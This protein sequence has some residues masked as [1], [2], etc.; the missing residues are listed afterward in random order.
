MKLSAFRNCAA[1]LVA[2]V[3]GCVPPSANDVAALDE[4]PLAPLQIVHVATGASEPD[5]SFGGFATGMPNVMKDPK[6]IK[7]S[8]FHINEQTYRNW[9]K[10]LR[11]NITDDNFK[12]TDCF[13]QHDCGPWIDIWA[14]ANILAKK[15]PDRLTTAMFINGVFNYIIDW[16]KFSTLGRPHD[17]WEILS[18]K[19]PL[20]ACKDYAAS[21]LQA[22]QGYFDNSNMRLVMG[23]SVHTETGKNDILHMVLSIRQNGV[24]WV[25]S[26]YDSMEA[27]SDSLVNKLTRIQ[28][29]SY[30]VNSDTKN[31]KGQNGLMGGAVAFLPVLDFGLEGSIRYFVDA[32]QRPPIKVPI[33]VERSV[34]FTD[35]IRVLPPDMQSRI[36]NVFKKIYETKHGLR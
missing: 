5:T 33:A 35:A 26:N 24:N 27:P 12:I 20:G 36:R 16:S 2:T 7:S 34:D 10:I 3:A 15:I 9:Q 17:A 14:E 4:T 18:G 1:L 11:K 28:P 23:E 21:K 32:Y 13:K 29:A 8:N 22:L 25:L 31:M 19:S 6:D 30:F